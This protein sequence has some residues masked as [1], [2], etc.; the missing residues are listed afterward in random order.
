MPVA[1]VAA[2]SVAAITVISATTRD[3]GDRDHQRI[4][5]HD[6]DRDRGGDYHRIGKSHSSFTEI[7]ELVGTDLDGLKTALGEGQT[8]A[9]IAEANDIDPQTVIDAL[10][11]SASERIDAAVEAGTLTEDEAAAKRAE[12]ND[13][14]TERVNS[15]IDLSESKRGRHGGHGRHGKHGGYGLGHRLT[16]FSSLAE[17][18]GTDLDGLKTA[19]GEGQTLAEIAEANGA[20][21]ENVVD[22]IVAQV[23]ERID[24]AVEDGK[25]TDEEAEA[26]RAEAAT[27][28]DD[29]VNNGFSK[30]DRDSKDDDETDADSGDLY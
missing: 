20:D 10:V 2:I 3:G 4:S 18:V 11:A 15:S 30:W 12:L 27:R 19:L 7:A 21:V 23:N 8:L 5:E 14:I 9:E 29:L 24:A 25:L 28:I 1:L 13:E 22:E 16:D 6:R 26:L 17:L